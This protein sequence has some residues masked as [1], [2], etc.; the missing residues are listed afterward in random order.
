M[1]ELNIRP[2]KTSSSWYIP[3]QEIE[4]KIWGIKYDRG[5]GAPCVP[6]PVDLQSVPLLEVRRKPP[7]PG[8]RKLAIDAL[9][10]HGSSARAR[11]WKL[12]R[13]LRELMRSGRQAERIRWQDSG[14][15]GRSSPRGRRRLE[16]TDR[17]R[18]ARNRRWRR[19]ERSGMIDLIGNRQLWEKIRVCKIGNEL[20][21]WD[22]AGVRVGR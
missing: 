2:P 10:P 14:A 5:G 21:A 7:A 20:A 22:G 1:M 6:G 13:V 15:I 19:E 3:I 11:R 12:P 8:V 4:K 17:T 18:R 16:K 9:L